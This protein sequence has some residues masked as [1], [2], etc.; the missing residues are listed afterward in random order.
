MKKTLLLLVLALPIV[1]TS[2]KK[3]KDTTYTLSFSMPTDV[4]ITVYILEYNKTGEIVKNNTVNVP[5]GVVTKEFTANKNAEK[6]KL[7]ITFGSGSYAET[8]WVQQ[9]YYL[10][11]G[12]ENFVSIVSS[13]LIG[14]K[15]P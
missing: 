12:K 3:E 5:G 11:I 2:C 6:L 7:Q 9:V 10:T 13:T 14:D 8:Y 4:P 1:F 15:E